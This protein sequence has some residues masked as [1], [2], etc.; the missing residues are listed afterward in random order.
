ME[1]NLFWTHF[2]QKELE[3]IYEYYREKAGVQVAKNLVNGIY[4]DPLKLKI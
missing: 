3:K 1:L 4:N 2:S